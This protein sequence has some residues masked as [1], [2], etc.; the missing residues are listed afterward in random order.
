MKQNPNGL[1]F[2]QT[3]LLLLS[4]TEHTWQQVSKGHSATKPPLAV[5]IFSISF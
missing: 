2:G 3:F 4:H 5:H 1:H